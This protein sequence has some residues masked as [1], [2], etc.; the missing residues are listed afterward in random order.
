MALVTLFHI[1]PSKKSSSYPLYCFAVCIHHLSPR[2]AI[3]FSL[4]SRVPN[5]S[6]SY[7]SFIFLISRDGG[8]V[9]TFTSGWDS[10]RSFDFT[11]NSRASR[12]VDSSSNIRLRRHRLRST[13]VTFRSDSP[14]CCR[15]YVPCIHKCTS[16]EEARCC[17]SERKARSTG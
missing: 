9:I 17:C 16:I 3:V 5:F 7:S 14:P 15:V 10:L 6:L 2:I 11:R 1:S 4:L 13:N 12:L 8:G